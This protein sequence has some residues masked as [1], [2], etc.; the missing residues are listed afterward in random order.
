[1]T[2]VTEKK[3]HG[4]KVWDVHPFRWCPGHVITVWHVR[5]PP[6]YPSHNFCV[7]PWMGA[8]WPTGTESA[9]G[10]HSATVVPICRQVR[11]TCGSKHWH[12]S[13]IDS[14]WLH[15]LMD[16]TVSM[17]VQCHP[18]YRTQE[19]ANNTKLAM[20][21]KDANHISSSEILQQQYSPTQWSTGLVGIHSGKGG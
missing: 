14:L 17:L 9:D 4:W 6:Q 7:C 20:S 15:V 18:A 19:I 10:Q 3:H 21:P 16:W 11:F 12:R 13:C 8:D 1:M 2:I 5:Q